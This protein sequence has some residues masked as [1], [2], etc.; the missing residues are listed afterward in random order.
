MYRK[1]DPMEMAVRNVGLEKTRLQLQQRNG[2]DTRRLALPA[3][4]VLSD[5]A[6]ETVALAESDGWDIYG[7]PSHGAPLPE[8]R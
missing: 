5:P 4:V 3:H 7:P 6:V 8:G 2:I 1:N